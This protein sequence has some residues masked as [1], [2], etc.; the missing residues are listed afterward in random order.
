MSRS[1]RVWL[2]LAWIG[3]AIGLNGWTASWLA[4]L[5]GGPGPRQGGMGFGAALTALAFLLLLCQGLAARGWCRGDAFVVS[6]ISL[7]VALIAVFVF[8]P[9]STILASAVQDN[10]GAF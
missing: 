2:A 5:F 8:F 4:A 6:S 10:A 7:V 3:Y 9:V 1:A